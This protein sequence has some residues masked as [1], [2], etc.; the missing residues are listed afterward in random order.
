MKASVGNITV[1]ASWR[2]FGGSVFVIRKSRIILRITRR[3]IGGVHFRWNGKDGLRHA[4]SR[5]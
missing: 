4:E 1:R 3:R 2:G 5:S